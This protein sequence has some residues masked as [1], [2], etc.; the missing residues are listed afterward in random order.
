[1]GRV[2]TG[3]RVETITLSRTQTRLLADR[4]DPIV[5]TYPS[6]VRAAEALECKPH[7]VQRVCSRR[8]S[9]MLAKPDFERLVE[10]LGIDISK[11]DL[12]RY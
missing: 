8:A 1:M 4:L 7:V 11:W 5:N 2:F 3:Q 12:T 10:V 9:V 6:Q